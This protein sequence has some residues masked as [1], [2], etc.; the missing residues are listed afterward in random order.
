MGGLT[1]SI[2][3][4]GFLPLK[5]CARYLTR[6]AFTT[7]DFRQTQSD[8]VM[9]IGL[10]FPQQVFL[11]MEHLDSSFDKLLDSLVSAAF[12]VLLNQLFQF[13]LQMDGHTLVH[14]SVMRH[15]D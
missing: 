9:G 13:G 1:R 8:L 12:D 3:P 4:I 6:Y 2:Q 10:A 11:F 14:A 15:T 5:A 7:L